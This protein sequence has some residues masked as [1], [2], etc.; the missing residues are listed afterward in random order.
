MHRC[1][2]VLFVALI[3]ALPPAG[4]QQKH[5]ARHPAATA[6]SSSDTDKLPPEETVNEFMHQMFGYDPS[7]TWKV[8]S[9]RP[10]EAEGLAEVV[11]QMSSPQGQQTNTFYVSPDGKHAV[12]GE[13]IPFG[14]HPFA[15]D[16]RTLKEGADGPSR[17]S[18]NAPVT[19]VE[20]SDLQCPHCKAAQPAIDK[21]LSENSNVRLV[22]ENFPLPMHDWATK[23]AEYAD[24]VGRSSNDA[25][26]KFIEGVYNAQSDITAANADDKLTAL[27]DQSGA[28]G[29]AISTCA[30][31]PETTSRVQRSVALGKILGVNSTPTAFING[32]K[33][34]IGGLP[35]EVLNQLV[36]FAAKE[37]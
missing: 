14:A 27:A 30:A 6:N 25:F 31:K 32:R 33:V 36:D 8:L 34:S 5:A 37:Q 1:P 19:L 23:A 17:G 28:D 26:W 16:E 22:F 18:A 7:L 10:A 24:C 35:E 12:I 2:I 11:V 9:I 4:A 29:A 13:I 3:L 20:F 15:A 21:L